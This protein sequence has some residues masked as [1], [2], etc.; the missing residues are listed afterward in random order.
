MM[1]R[2]TATLLSAALALQ[3]DAGL[4]CSEWLSSA[5]DAESPRYEGLY[6][7]CVYGYSLIVPRGWIGHGEAPGSPQHGIGIRRLVDSTGYIWTDGSHNSLDWKSLDQF[8]NA[9]VGYLR[10]SGAI[11]LSVRKIPAALDRHP[12][13][14]T[15]VRYRCGSKQMVSDQFVCFSRDKNDCYVLS[16]VAEQKSYWAYKSVLEK[17]AAA[18]RF[19]QR[20]ANRSRALR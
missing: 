3:A 9:Q 4:P 11:I 14:R 1:L 17:V 15:V 20:C 8:A 10:A 7:N 6:E 12:A 16:L 18:W 2:I 19:R 13:V 5:D